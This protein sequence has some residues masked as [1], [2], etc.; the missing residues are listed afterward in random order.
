MPP[1]ARFLA[2]DTLALPGLRALLLSAIATF[3]AAPGLADADTYQLRTE[4]KRAI[5]A[6]ETG[7][8]GEFR[9][10]LSA[11]TDY[12]LH[13]YL[14]YFDARRRLSRM[15]AGEAAAFKARLSDTHLGD[16]LFEAWLITQARRGH[17]QTY[18]D[19]YEPMER[20]DGRCFYARSLYRT[21]DREAA[22]GM[23]PELWIVGVSQP[24]ECDPLFAVWMAQ[25]L[26]T[27]DMAWE[28]LRLALAENERSLARYLLGR[29]SSARASA[30]RALYDGHVRPG[31]VRRPSRFPNTPHGAEALGHALARY[32][33]GNAVDAAKQWRTLA[34][35]S[36]PDDTRAFIEERLTAA[37]ARAGESVSEHM[38]EP[39]GEPIRTSGSATFVHDMALASVVHQRWSEAVHWIE[40]MDEAERDTR[41][42]RY[43][44]GRA[45]LSLDPDSET[46]KT[47]LAELAKFRSYYGF[48]AAQKLGVEPSL[49]ARPAASASRPDH[50]AIERMLELYA[51]GD[52]VNARR[53][54]NWMFE[55]FSAP[56]QSALIELAAD[57]GWINQAIYGANRPELIDLVTLRFPTP[58]LH[59]YQRLAFQTDLRLPLLL[60]VTRKES[61][62]N[63]RAVSPSGAV[64]LM[65]LMPPTARHT[66]SRARLEQ[67]SQRDLFD[68]VANIEL[69]AHYLA[70][71]MDRY[72]GHRVLVAG[73][74]N[75]GPTRV[76]GWL[77]E[78]RDMPADA[79]IEGIPISETRDYVQAVLAFDLVYT[80]LL[81]EPVSTLLRPDEEHVP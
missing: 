46:G 35:R 34:G 25:G 73:A 1:R 63:P 21:G 8:S 36:M 48:L 24:K 19:H 5:N 81:G 3:G 74:Y 14:V 9:S 52:L 65:Q 79:W 54:W 78:R 66:A 7:H 57:I 45:L 68:P 70:E 28:R 47:S 33:R 43:W 11:L 72:D 61:A 40:S 32:A 76:A 38:G 37:L 75:A 42:W 67:P 56:D 22:L 18:R 41:E 44:L 30:A 17:W 59:L 15:S 6:I 60:A 13:P 39:S 53:E 62:F 69:G 31:N 55:K 49:N 4:Y 50:P 77:R 51:V 2:R 20:A 71:L 16:R 80:Q 12:P 26:L 27:D 64:G 10:A 29:F 23:V 58:Y